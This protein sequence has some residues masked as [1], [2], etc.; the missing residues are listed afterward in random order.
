[1][2]LKKPAEAGDM[3]K[4]IIKFEPLIE[5]TVKNFFP[6][7]A[8]VTAWAFDKLNRRSEA[9]QWL[10]DQIRDFPNFNLL[11]WSK[12]V[13]EKDNIFILHEDEKDATVVILE[14]LTSAKM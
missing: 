10:N 9:I 5:N 12:S 3:L 1:M 7:N 13:F 6:A 14:K 2:Q 8:L 11:L 4:R